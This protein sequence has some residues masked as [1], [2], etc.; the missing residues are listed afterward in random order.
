MSESLLQI[1]TRIACVAHAG[2]V[3]KQG[4]PYIFHVMRVALAVDGEEARTLALL[5]DV[6]EDTGW[7]LDDVHGAGIPEE[8]VISLRY[9]TRTKS[10][11]YAGYI[12]GLVEYG[13]PAAIAVKLADLADNLRPERISTLPPEQAAS[14][15]KRYHAA[16]RRLS[17][18]GG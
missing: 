5:H 11:T 7:S 17:E 1:A 4:E 6:V 9:L 12:E 18:V 13:D 8:V 15:S 2:Q 14:L 10:E 16:Y 3:D